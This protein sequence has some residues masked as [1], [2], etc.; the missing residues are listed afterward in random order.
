MLKFV[1]KTVNLSLVFTGNQHLVEFS[2]IMKVSFQLMKREDFYTHYFIGV[3][4]YVVISRHLILKLIIWRLS[5]WKTIIPRISL[6]RVLNHF[7]ISCI[8]L[9]LLFRMY[10][11][12]M[13]LLNCPSWEVLCFKFERSFKNYLMTNWHL[14]I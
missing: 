1:I 9:K 5:L 13:F 12:E 6:I 8:H 2:P 7:L 10:L 14:V 11:K 4:A 3:L